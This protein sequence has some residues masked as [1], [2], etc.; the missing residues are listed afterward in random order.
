MAESSIDFG[1]LR[2]LAF[3]TRRYRSGEV[4]FQKGDVGFEMYFI[5]DGEVE[6]RIGERVLARLAYGDIFGEMALVDDST[7]S[8]SAIA[9][10]DVEIVPVSEK[11][12]VELIRE[13]PSFAIDIMRLLAQRL[14]AET[15]KP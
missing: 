15:R 8:A 14:R 3:D 1:L 5:K 2:K 12:F 10:S 9:V 6:L 4:I 13:A 11:Q 7:R